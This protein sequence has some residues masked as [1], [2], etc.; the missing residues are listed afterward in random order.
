MAHPRLTLLNGLP[1]IDEWPGIDINCLSEAHQKVAERRVS[2]LKMYVLGAAHQTIESATG[3]P[4]PEVHRLLK[5]CLSMSADGR[6][7]GL[8]ALVPGMRV[9]AYKR[10]AHVQ[11]APGD[12]N[13]GCAGALE[14]VFER[15]PDLRK[16]VHSEFL[17]MT[18]RRKRGDARIR[19][20]DLHAKFIRWLEEHG[21]KATEWP[22]NTANE[23]LEALRR[24][25]HSLLDAEPEKWIRA[26]SGQEAARRLTVG[27]GIA[28][29]MPMLR[30][31]GAVQ[32]DFHKVDSAC[33]I[34]I[35][36]SFGCEVR[37]PLARWHIG[38][39]IEERFELILGA[40][41]A[42]ELT[43]SADS[44][45][46]TLECGIVPIS[47]ESNGCAL[48][49]G[50][51]KHVF[52]NQQ[53][54]ALNG[55]CFSVLRMD[56]GWS[57]TARDVIDNVIDTIGC[58]VHFGPVKA[59]WGRDTIERVF[60]QVTRTGLQRSPSTYG[61][62]PG[63]TR[64]NDPNAQAEDLDIRLSDIV[65]A[66]SHAIML[67]NASRTAAL[68]MGSP[69]QALEAAMHNP[70]SG[71]VPSPLPQ[72]T[73]ELPLLMYHVEVA[74]VRGS[75]KKGERPFVKIAGWRYTNVR[76][77][78]DFTLLGRHLRL[79]CSRR[80]VRV[81]YASVIETGEVIGNLEPPN[82]WRE[83]R[84]DWRS[85]QLI[86][87]A[88]AVERRKMRRQMRADEWLP[89]D[90][91]GPACAYD[92]SANVTSKRALEEANKAV[93]WSKPELPDRQNTGPA[94]S[95]L[96][97]QTVLLAG[98]GQSIALDSKINIERIIQGGAT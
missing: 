81:V 97:H 77:A 69:L 58:A 44:V 53:F 43:P 14:Q 68:L 74:T 79:Y 80:D 28:P 2:A 75:I 16:A 35:T 89:A 88:G 9:E 45:L 22:L 13:Q 41:L 83:V 12:S 33:V 55:Q 51:G 87:S 15:F 59:W 56:N 34:H 90:D 94:S 23:G 91:Y 54:S 62:N 64:K 6:I 48:A 73:S 57:N 24:Y 82:R 5:R 92:E 26:R 72:N 98:D 11:C 4:R 42:L 86:W 39:L 96:S 85:R 95:K 29:V 18:P 52:P 84:L 46:E 20:C 37:V 17:K 78:N 31:F 40:V 1:P 10:I 8:R 66:I 3:I 38:V 71:F 63:D 65:S 25:C 36:N 47:Q 60:G 30:P 49:I 61:S 50:L 67:Q 70:E 19:I 7:F 27:R 76:L 21:L 93:K 32:L